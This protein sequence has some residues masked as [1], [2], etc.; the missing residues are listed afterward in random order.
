MTATHAPM[1][2]AAPARADAARW[3]VVAAALCLVQFSEPFFAAL[4]QSQGATEPPGYARIFFLPVYAFLGWVVWRQARTAAR[5]VLAV[6]L[7]MAL[8]LLAGAS[9]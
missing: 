6:P 8:V 4:A 2:A 7:L 1:E 9:T 3:E 5:T